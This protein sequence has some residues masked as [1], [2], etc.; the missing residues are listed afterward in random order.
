MTDG[1]QVPRLRGAPTRPLHLCV[2]E[3]C[4][5]PPLLFLLP[6]QLCYLNLRKEAL[7]R[8]INPYILPITVEER[9]LER[10]TQA[11]HGHRSFWLLLYS[12][13]LISCTCK[14]VVGICAQGIFSSRVYSTVPLMTVGTL[15]VTRACSVP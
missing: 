9:K 14:L 15:P 13:S 5:Y 3:R 12:R 11:Q 6:R 1:R 2:V 4:T 7:I 10:L 8:K